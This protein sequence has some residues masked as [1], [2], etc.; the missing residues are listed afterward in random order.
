MHERLQES[1]KLASEAAERNRK[2]Q[3]KHYDI[4][5]RGSVLHP[6]DRVLVRNLAFDGR[7]KI[8]DRW[9][10]DAYI[11]KNQ[12]NKDVLVFMVRKENEHGRTRTI[13]RNLLLSIGS[14]PIMHSRGQE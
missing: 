11:I 12:P 13:H 1:Y 3:K 6:G 10:E 2:H 5:V 7:H 8:A 9:E 14:L 4:K